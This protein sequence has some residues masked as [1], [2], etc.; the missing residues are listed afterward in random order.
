MACADNNVENWLFYEMKNGI[1]TLTGEGALAGDVLYLSHMPSNF[2]FGFQYG[3]GAN[4]KNCNEGLS[5]WFTY[6]GFVNGLAVEGHGDV[7]VDADCE[8]P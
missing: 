4:N 5:G 2:Y 3:I 8:A 7:N 1:S 6:E